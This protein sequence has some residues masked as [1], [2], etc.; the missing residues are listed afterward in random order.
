MKL[1]TISCAALVSLTLGCDPEG[2]D[3][4]DQRCFPLPVAER[5]GRVDEEEQG[6]SLQGGTLP[7]EKDQ[8]TS[9][10]GGRRPDEDLQGT[11]LG[12]GRGVPDRENNGTTLAIG[13]LN[14]VRLSV[15]ATSAPV[16]S[17]DGELVADGHPDTESLRDVELAAVT[18]HGV[19][20]TVRV[21]AVDVGSIELSSG[22][23]N[24]CGDGGRGVFVAGGW[25]A[26]GAHADDTDVV[27]FSCEDGVIAKCVGWGYSP[28]DTDAQTHQGCTRMARADYCG[29][30]VSWTLDGTIVDLYD[31]LGVQQMT[32]DSRFRFEAAW[33]PDGAICASRTRYEIVD[34]GD[35]VLPPCLAALP[36]CES[37]DD[38]AAQGATLANRSEPT[39][40]DACR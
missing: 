11:S 15:A 7:G 26:R 31:R 39:T 38:A 30:G 33:G 1:R 32:P 27:T 5:A 37:L 25:D 36:E 20:S 4:G 22:G 29:D 28:W 21:I 9:L 34:D 19:E 35:V 24:V 2:Q 12:G 23:V 40:I 13:D 6:R 10:Q 3:A 18:S 14:G 17:S 16:R 8:G